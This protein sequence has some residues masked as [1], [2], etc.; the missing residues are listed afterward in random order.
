[1][2]LDA[3]KDFLAH[4]SP[5]FTCTAEPDGVSH[6]EYTALIEHRGTSPAG[7]DLQ[8]L[9]GGLDQLIE[10]YSTFGSLRLYCD[11]NSSSSAFYFAKPSEWTQLQQEFLSSLIQ[12]KMY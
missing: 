12:Y 10:F 5:R 3:L 6:G 2:N 9:A 7:D 11:T 1:M 4:D 8:T